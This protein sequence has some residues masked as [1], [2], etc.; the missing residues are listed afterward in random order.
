MHQINYVILF[1]IRKYVCL[2][3]IY[4][5]C[6]VYENS[7]EDITFQPG[8]P[9]NFQ[10]YCRA[11]QVIIAI[12][13]ADANLVQCVNKYK[14]KTLICQFI[15]GSRNIGIMNG[16]VRKILQYFVD[17]IELADYKVSS[18]LARLITII[19]ETAFDRNI[20]SE[21]L[22]LFAMEF[23]QHL[24]LCKNTSL[25]EIAFSKIHP[26]WLSQMICEK[27][28]DQY[29]NSLLSN[30]EPQNEIC[31]GSVIS[32][33]FYLHPTFK[34]LISTPHKKKRSTPPK[35]MAQRNPAAKWRNSRGESKLHR[36]CITNNIPQVKQLLA[37]PGVNVNA[38]D[39]YGWTALHECCNHGHV[40]CVKLLLAH[41]PVMSME[42]YLNKATKHCDTRAV[43]KD[44]TTPLHDAVNNGQVCYN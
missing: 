43:S 21:S 5:I 39:N 7:T 40:E 35:Q 3:K 20:P 11:F 41:K 30:L 6:Q 2:T 16:N 44:G 32:K 33:S 24:K 9:V 15:W 31:L 29:D 26:S 37:T 42:S 36:A 19:V 27:M 28:L 1:L 18:L 8:K 4:C 34:Q 25:L 13:D 10:N 12:L 23:A 38:A 22:H 14:C 17:S